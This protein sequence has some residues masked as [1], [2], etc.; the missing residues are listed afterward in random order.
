MTSKV[1][2]ANLALSQLGQKSIQDFDEGSVSSERVSLQY[3]SA[4][5]ELMSGADF[6][7]ARHLEALSLFD[8]DPQDWAF[9]YARPAE[10][11]LLTIRYI[12]PWRVTTTET[13][14]REF[15]KRKF[16]EHPTAVDYSKIAVAYEQGYNDTEQQAIFTNLEEAYCVYTFYQEDPVRW[17]Q[18][19][20]A[21]FQWY[22]AAMLAVPCLD[23][24]KGLKVR[25]SILEKQFAP[26]WNKAL[27]D[28]GNQQVKRQEYE[29]AS[30]MVR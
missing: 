11:E 28:N 17:T 22:L 6:F 30:H 14:Q 20:R 16:Y 15:L 8:F 18:T 3:D 2:I 10:K 7:F 24:E 5:R 29:P 4:C 12:V 13:D 25:D 27:A 1:E 26:A 23:F 19:F 21:A 9:A